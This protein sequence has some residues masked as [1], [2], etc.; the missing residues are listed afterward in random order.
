MPEYD[1]GSMGIGCVLVAKARGKHKGELS[2]D[3][4]EEVDEQMLQLGSS[5]TGQRVD[6]TTTLTENRVS[7]EYAY[8]ESI[9]S[10]SLTH[11]EDRL[12]AF[13]V[14]EEPFIVVDVKTAEFIEG[15]Q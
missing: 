15:E 12:E 8:Q 5:R 9:L 4:L 14:L 2:I 1:A 13:T 3:E 10:K 7:I 11:A 6:V